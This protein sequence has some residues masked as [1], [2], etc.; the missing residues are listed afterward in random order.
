MMAPNGEIREE[1]HD[2][3][4]SIN[5]GRRKRPVT[6]RFILAVFG[7]IGG[8]WTAGTC[9]GPMWVRPWA[10]PTDIKAVHDS[11]RATK[12]SADQAVAVV[13]AEHEATRAEL[14]AVAEN[15]RIG[16][17]VL[18]VSLR[19]DHPDLLTPGCTETI[20][21]QQPPKQLEATP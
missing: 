7:I 12:A 14:R 20:K 3:L 4:V 8:L 16:N 6:S 11:I 10:R 9:I 5:V 21:A 17:Y 13:R 2:P 19:R 1:R 18:C 15:Q